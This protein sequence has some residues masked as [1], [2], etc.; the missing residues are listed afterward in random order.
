MKFA[1]VDSLTSDRPIAPPAA[2]LAPSPPADPLIGHQRFARDPLTSFLQIRESHGDVVRLQFGTLTAHLVSDP[3]LVQVVLQDRARIYG[4]QTRGMRQLRTFLGDG[5][6]TSEGDFWLRQRRIAQP[7]FKREPLA[8]LLPAMDQAAKG[9]A[10][11][12]DQVAA[13]SETVDI[14]TEMT[15]LTLRTLPLLRPSPSAV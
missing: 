13:R 3:A 10:E 7:A 4:K 2:R 12:L 5:L 9:A 11:R 8:A 15:R 1:A 6:L 14:H